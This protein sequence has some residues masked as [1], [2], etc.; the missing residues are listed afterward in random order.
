MRAKTCEYNYNKNNIMMC[1]M[2]A[3]LR[4]WRAGNWQLASAKRFDGNSVWY[5][6]GRRC[7]H[8]AVFNVGGTGRG[9]TTCVV[10]GTLAATADPYEFGVII[11]INFHSVCGCG[12]PVCLCSLWLCALRGPVWS[13]WTDILF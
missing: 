11:I 4:Q 3:T 6:G 13:V 7:R 9:I 12:M 2:H 10:S 5:R 1:T 8:A